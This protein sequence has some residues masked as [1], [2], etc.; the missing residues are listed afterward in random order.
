MSK[1]YRIIPTLL[2]LWLMGWVVLSWAAIQDDALIHLRYADNLYRTHLITYD[3]VH[4]NYGASSLLYVSLL[5]VLTPFVH[6]P[7]LPR[8]VSSVAHL[9]LFGG[10]VLLITRFIPRSTSL[11]RLLGLGFL[12]FLAVPS[13]VRWLDDG[14]E[15]GLC[16][17]F[18]ALICFLAFRSSRTRS[19]NTLESVIFV[20]VAFFS[21]SLR[22]ET[23][24]LCAICSAI[25]TIKALEESNGEARSLVDRI[26]LWFRAVLRSSY[27]LIG[28][29]LALAATVYRMHFLLPD[30]ALAKSHGAGIWLSVVLVSGHI[31]L[32]ALSFG[33][34]FFFF[35]LLTLVLLF[36]AGQFSSSVLL[37]NVVFPITLF[38]ASIRGQEIQGAR[39]LIWT[40]FFSTLWNILELAI[41]SSSPTHR[42]E[43]PVGRKLVYAFA[44]LILIVQPVESR[45]MY[46]VLSA[47]A[48][49]LTQFQRQHLDVL[50]EK[51]G[52]AEDVGYIGYFS[53]AQICDIAGLVN[54]RAAASLDMWKRARICAALDPD[55]LFLN[56][57]QIVLMTRYMSLDDWLICGQYDFKNIDTPDT[58]YLLL[59]PAT[60]PGGCAAATGQSPSPVT[61]L[62]SVANPSS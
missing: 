21:V 40:F 41:P 25:L 31:L 24:L 38:L 5:A 26:G 29:L 49:T 8:G 18:T 22:T 47:R 48:K 53:K 61:S 32:S 7:N 42:T 57:S 12:G 39:Y 4:P 15:T 60:A 16:L 50:H 2:A 11:A 13:A 3:G 58:H 33:L 20:T 1:A 6:S 56:Q 36:R 9:I 52:V 35:W 27:L 44:A 62:L 34:G 10:I 46:S 51:L 28:G 30:T 17:S 59:P 23:I 37:A 45:V 14:M 19:A 43:D 54:G 55:F